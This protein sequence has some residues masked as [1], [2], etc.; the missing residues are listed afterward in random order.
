MA[1]HRY[2]FPHLCFT[3]AAQTPSEDGVV[4]STSYDGGGGDG[5]IGLPIPTSYSGGGDDGTAT[6]NDPSILMGM[7]AC[8]PTTYTSTWTDAMVPIPTSFL[9][10]PMYTTT[11]IGCDPPGGNY[12]VVPGGT[13]AIGNNNN[14]GNILNVGGDNGGTIKSRFGAA[15]ALAVILA[16]IVL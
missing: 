16:A 1:R 12:T 7:I 14:Q 5:I 11:Y 10:T 13:S 8:I 4:T 6:V 3:V 9:P 2:Q 15:G